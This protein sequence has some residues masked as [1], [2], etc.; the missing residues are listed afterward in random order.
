[1]L[2]KTLKFND[3]VLEILRGMEWNAD[4]TIGKLTCGNLSARPGGR[5][6]YELVDK[7]LNAM[8]GKWNR[9]AG[10]HI[11]PNDPRAQVE[12]LLTNGALTVERDGFFET[13]EAVVW[14]ML[15]YV[16][17][18]GYS[19]I[20]LEPSAGMG[21]IL[22]VLQVTEYSHFHSFKACEKNDKRRDHLKREFP[23]IEI[24]GSDFLSYELPR[25]SDGEVMYRFDRIYMNPPFE[26]MQDVDHVRHAY[27]LLKDDGK[28][29]SVMAESAFF[30]SDRKA[31]EFREWLDSVWGDSCELPEG[32]FKDSGTGVKVRLVVIEK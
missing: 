13:P 4:G 18:P 31:V 28:M 9:K 12:G 2:T 10:G 1:M 11:F 14:R 19:V 23:D 22:K 16:P 32:A 17:L 8:G 20:V 5:K 26:E 27:S 15:D 29:V 21:A 24:V 3:D 25:H 30:R 6:L 7:A